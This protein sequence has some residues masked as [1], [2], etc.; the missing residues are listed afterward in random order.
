MK[1]PISFPF[2]KKEP[3]KDYYLVLLLRDEKVS[4]VI[5]EEQEAQI[6]VKNLS[7][8]SLQTPLSKLELETF[9]QLLDRTISK[10]EE[11]LPPNVQTEKTIF[12]VKDNWV[13]EKK[14]KKEHLDVLK[15]IGNTLGLKPIGFLVISEAIAHQ[16]QEEEGAPLSGLVVELGT[17]SATITLFKGGRLIETHTGEKLE[18]H[19]QTVDTLLKHFS[20]ADVFPSR[21][22]ILNTGDS[23]NLEQEFLSHQWSKSI[24]FLHMPQISILDSHFDAISA[25]Y[26]ASSQ[27]GF[28]VLS[29]E[30]TKQAINIIPLSPIALEDKETEEKKDD[31]EAEKSETKEEKE[32][33]DGKENK[34]DDDEKKH[35][36]KE[37]EKELLKANPDNFG[38]VSEEDIAS[39]IPLATPT[40]TPTPA[41]LV[42]MESEK[43]EDEREEEETEN[44]SPSRLSQ[45][46]NFSTMLSFLPKGLSLPH[47]SLGALSGGRVPKM[48]MIAG[49]ALIVLL[50]LIPF[51]Y[52]SFAKV[53]ITLSVKEKSFSD[54]TTVTFAVDEENS[55]TDNVIGAKTVSVTIEGEDSAEATGKKDIG[56]KAKGA[57]TLYNNGDSPRTIASGTVLKASNNVEFT[58]DK[59]VTI[60]SASGD[61]FSGTKPGT[62]Q[63]AV[64]AKTLGPEGNLPSNT[65]FTI[66]GSSVLAAK[67]DTAFSGGNKKSLTVVSK[68]DRDKLQLQLPKKLG[69]K[70]KEEI[71]A[72]ISN[73]EIL[74]PFDLETSFD[75]KEFD[76]AVDEEAKRVTLKGTITFT[77]VIYNKEDIKQ[78]TLE[79]VK[80]KTSNDISLAENKL[81]QELS[82][83]KRDGDE[84]SA[85]LSIKA[86]LLP[87]LD[88]QKLQ[89]TVKGKGVEEALTSLR[90]LPQTEKVEIAF[91]PSL[92]LLN[93]SLPSKEGNITF[94]INSYE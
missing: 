37:S 84:I 14:I 67:N 91:K 39:T 92:P 93:G 35:D 3:Q 57:V 43:E 63:G 82:G 13:E 62:S 32:D 54:E 20:E 66:G 6:T 53:T 28:K 41:S 45:R 83:M 89:Q 94:V 86:G 17:F 69:D 64:T 1:L 46:R 75:K 61:I 16:V 36:E 22:L 56:E 77:G 72:K 9:T 2:G 38:F 85:K 79:K 18:T 49:I 48:G 55:F 19:T 11:L 31:K 50:I 23:P 68:T 78:Y 80:E 60:A 24:P 70:A 27:M 76:R 65:K 10:A 59:E 42:A 7:E 34:K 51:L 15:Q 87:S 88:T 29:T 33:T 73:D 5:L 74:L 58:L 71:T 81:T 40:P 21:L 52:K 26:G 8:E 30:L 12:G 47:L 25:V 90:S 44:T 4:A